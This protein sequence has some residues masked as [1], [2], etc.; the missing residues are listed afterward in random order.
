MGPGLV[1]WLFADAEL[2]VD[3]FSNLDVDSLDV[4]MDLNGAVNWYDW[5]ESAKNMEL[6]AGPNGNG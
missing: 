1:P 6:D 2:S 4:D 5:V 3:V